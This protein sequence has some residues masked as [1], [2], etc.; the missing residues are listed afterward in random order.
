M[1]KTIFLWW[2]LLLCGVVSIQAQVKDAATVYSEF[3]HWVDVIKAAEPQSEEYEQAAQAMLQLFPQL[4]YHAAKYSQ[5]KQ[6]GNAMS[7]A[8]AYVDLAMMP[9]FEAM[10]LETVATDFPLLLSQAI[11]SES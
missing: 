9:Q 3:A 5:Q 2:T 1:K 4:H 6:L 11:Y 7:F 10:H 8:K